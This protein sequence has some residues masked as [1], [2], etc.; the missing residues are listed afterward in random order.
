MDI[1]T[2]IGN[3]STIH[4]AHRYLQRITG[5]RYDVEL[6]DDGIL[7]LNYN[8]RYPHTLL[9][10]K[11]IIYNNEIEMYIFLKSDKHYYSNGALYLAAYIYE[12]DDVAYDDYVWKEDFIMG[13]KKFDIYHTTDSNKMCSS[14]FKWYLRFK[15]IIPLKYILSGLTYISVKK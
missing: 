14:I 8:N 1:I 4:E 9:Y 15:K 3:F 6:D 7:S 10:S 11:Q 12:L 2:K 5:C 13:D